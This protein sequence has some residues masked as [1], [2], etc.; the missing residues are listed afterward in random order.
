MEVDR[1]ELIRER[2]HAIWEEEG[3][4]EGKDRQHWARATAEVDATEAGGDAEVEAPDILKT[5]PQ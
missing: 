1:E 5:T 3:R 2:A 4:P